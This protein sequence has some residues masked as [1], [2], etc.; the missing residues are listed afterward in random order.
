M[1]ARYWRLAIAGALVF[2][3]LPVAAQPLQP[4]VRDCDIQ[5]RGLAAGRTARLGAC[6]ALGWRLHLAG[7]EREAIAVLSEV[8]RLVP[9][10]EKAF[11]ALG[12][13]YLFT[14]EY[15]EAAAANRAALAVRPNG[16]AHYNLSLALWELGRFKE[17]ADHAREAVRFEPDNPHPRVALAIARWQQGD[18][19]AALDAYRGAVRLDRRYQR[20]AYLDSL[21]ASDFSPRQIRAA[22][23]VQAALR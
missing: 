8:T 14:G 23:T 15:A 4:W 12:V 19:N 10:D 22:R 20:G 18:R 13:I 6:V 7:R 21:A 2:C 11:N 1:A 5:K 3:Y 17:A 16:T 9:G